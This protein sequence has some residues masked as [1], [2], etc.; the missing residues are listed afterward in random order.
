MDYSPWER[1]FLSRLCE[2]IF[3]RTI[4]SDK[5]I[6]ILCSHISIDLNIPSLETILLNFP[7]FFHPFKKFC[8]RK[9]SRFFEESWDILSRNFKDHIYS[10]EQ[11]SWNF[12]LISFDLCKRT[13]TRF[14]WVFIKSAFTRIHW[15]DKHDISWILNRSTCTRDIDYSILK[16]LS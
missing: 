12:T 5:L 4:K 8:W 2:K 15:C 1:K 7:G 6:N 13:R 3:T 14:V 16:R 9:R 11:W 10:I